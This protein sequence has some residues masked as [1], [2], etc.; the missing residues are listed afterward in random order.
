[1]NPR[2]VLFAANIVS[3]LSLV[4][5]IDPSLNNVFAQ[6]G[7]QP[8][9]QDQFPNLESSPSE[10]I[11]DGNF[12][13][14]SEFNSPL[15][16]EQPEFNPP[17]DINGTYVNPDVGLQIDLPKDWSGKEITF[18]L[19]LVVAAPPGVEIESLEA[20]GTAM[21]IQVL[22]KEAFDEVARTQGGDPLAMQEGDQCK[23]LPAS[24]VTINGLK[25]EQRSG[26]CINEE[27]SNTKIKAYTFATADGTVILLAFSSDS[28][29]EYKRNL[30]QFEES[31]KTI[32]ISQPGNIATS[33]LYQ[34]HKEL[35]IQ[36]QTSMTTS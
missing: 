20:E 29:I 18:L 6:G 19:D 9:F 3:I 13:E 24:F 16:L 26:D 14:P 22:D 11:T 2:V 30:P 33:E 34:K 7:E 1:M 31:V 36:S 17:R 12:S 27:G 28:I 32:K 8:T 25:A 10:P 35:E 4:A 21:V 5:D 15:G 23:E